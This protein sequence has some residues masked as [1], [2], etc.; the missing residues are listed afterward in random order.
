MFK[1]LENLLFGLIAM[2]GFAAAALMTASFL[3][4]PVPAS[5]AGTLHRVEPGHRTGR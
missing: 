2:T 4:G 5:A 1:S 3:F